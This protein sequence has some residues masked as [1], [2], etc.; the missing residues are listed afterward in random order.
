MRLSSRVHVSALAC[1]LLCLA[2]CDDGEPPPLDSGVDAALDGVADGTPS[3]VDT[4]SPKQDATVHDAGHDVGG[5][6]DASGDTTLGGDAARDASEDV[7][8]QGC[9]GGAICAS[10]TVCI[11]GECR[12]AG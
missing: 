5:A 11:G 1:S 6:H 10:G 8:L 12:A 4:G 7:P 2:A 9:G 3:P